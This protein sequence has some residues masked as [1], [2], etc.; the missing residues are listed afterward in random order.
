VQR[1]VVAPNEL[2]LETPYLERNIAFTRAA[3]ALENIEEREYSAGG[4]LDA[5]TIETNR[6]TVDNIRLWDWRPLSQTFRQLQQIRT[7]Y[8]FLDVDID[9]YRF[10]D[11]YRQ[12]LL[13]ARELAPELPGKRNT[14]V[15]RRLQFTHGYGAVMSPASGK[16]ADGRPVLLVKDFGAWSFVPTKSAMVA[17]RY[18]ALIASNSARSSGDTSSS[19]WSRTRNALRPSPRP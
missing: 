18:F 19:L 13:S 11:D 10:G 8:T 14:W 5:G 15:N 16:T 6:P 4:A 3:F 1:F 7:Y 9:R 12:V 17:R 2:E